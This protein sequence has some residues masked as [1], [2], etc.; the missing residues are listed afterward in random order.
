MRGEP[1]VLEK[2]RKKRPCDIYISTITIAEILYGIKKSPARIKE[3]T[4]KLS[5]IRSNIEV[6]P[7]DEEAA[8]YYAQ[9][10]CSLE[11]E[12]NIISERDLQI[13]SIAL[14]YKLCLITHNVSE[15][16]RIAHLQW[17]DWYE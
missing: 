11:A 2:L 12:G 15:F 5:L 7:F 6:L 8:E 4:N 10:R 1:S 17:E 16:S 3:R 14:A 9:S 13:A